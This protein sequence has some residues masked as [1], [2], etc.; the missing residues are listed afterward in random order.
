M[1]KLKMSNR[2]KIALDKSIK[3]WKDVVDSHG[4]SESERKK[5]AQ[6]KIDFLESYYY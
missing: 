2:S 3:H 1:K 6:E 4:K 5:L